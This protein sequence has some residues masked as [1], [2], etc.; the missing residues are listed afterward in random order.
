[1]SV[2]N[3]THRYARPTAPRRRAAR[4]S[5]P[6]YALLRL[7]ELFVGQHPARVKV[8]D[9]FKFGAGCGGGVC[10]GRL[11]LVSRCAGRGNEGWV[12]L[13]A[14]RQIGCRRAARSAVLIP[15]PDL[16]FLVQPLPCTRFALRPP[17]ASVLYPRIGFGATVR[18]RSCPTI[19]GA[20][21]VRTVAVRAPPGASAAADALSLE[22]GVCARCDRSITSGNVL[23]GHRQRNDPPNECPSKKRLMTAI[24]PRLVT[25]RWLAMIV[26]RKYRPRTIPRTTRPPKKP[27]DESASITRPP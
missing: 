27:P 17:D 9:P 3:L 22:P 16:G 24:E 26:G 23:E 11:D 6:K 7:L 2:S 18:A 5:P 10:C 15:P 14:R 19:H 20:P 4:A 12:D 25:P 21:A 1:M 13:A 8:G